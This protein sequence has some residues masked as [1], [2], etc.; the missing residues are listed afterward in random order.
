MYH[1]TGNRSGALDINSFRSFSRYSALAVYMITFCADFLRALLLSYE[2]SASKEGVYISH[3][4][5][6]AF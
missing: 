1:D 4:L 5:A 3:Q 6:P 2:G